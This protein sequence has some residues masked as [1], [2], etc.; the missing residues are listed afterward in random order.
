MDYDTDHGESRDVPEVDYD[1]SGDDTM[2]EY[3]GY[4]TDDDESGGAS[5]GAYRGGPYIPELHT[6]W[7]SSTTIDPDYDHAYSWMKEEHVDGHKSYWREAWAKTH[8]VH[9]TYYLDAGN[10]LDPAVKQAR[11]RWPPLIFNRAELYIQNY[12][13]IKWDS[14]GAR[15]QFPGSANWVLVRMLS[16]P[17]VELW[18]DPTTLLGEKS[19]KLIKEEDNPFQG[20]AIAAHNDVGKIFK[21][22]RHS[23]HLGRWEPNRNFYMIFDKPEVMMIGSRYP[24][25]SPLE[26]DGTDLKRL[27]QPPDYRQHMLPVNPVTTNIILHVSPDEITDKRPPWFDRT[28]N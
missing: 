21:L 12:E 7:P 17:D 8:S 23:V 4:G 6:E 24:V 5:G 13:D 14:Y 2:D 28:M 16:N 22:Q 3:G 11:M 20:A 9:K 26:D 25:R 15:R 27:I 18:V 19:T 1:E 10:Y